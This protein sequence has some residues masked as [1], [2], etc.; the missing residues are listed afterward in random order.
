MGQVA[1]PIVTVIPKSIG[2]RNEEVAAR[3]QVHVLMAH[4]KV[5]AGGDLLPIELALVQEL[6]SL[7]LTTQLQ[8]TESFTRICVWL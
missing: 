8:R 4:E 3:T 7:M 6:L 5:K 2:T 1:T